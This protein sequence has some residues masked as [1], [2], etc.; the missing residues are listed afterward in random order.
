MH[1]RQISHWSLWCF[2]VI[3]VNYRTYEWRLNNHSQKIKL[4]LVYKFLF[5]KSRP[6][7]P[8]WGGMQPVFYERGRGHCTW[9]HFTANVL[10]LYSVCWRRGLWRVFVAWP[11]P[12][13]PVRGSKGVE[14]RS[15]K[16]SGLQVHYRPRSPNGRWFWQRW[17]D[18]PPKWIFWEKFNSLA[19]TTLCL[20]QKMFTA[21]AAPGP[22]TIKMRD[23]KGDLTI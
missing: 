10:T 12:E 9:P 21:E 2:R 1:G 4:S 8:G 14:K 18:S 5:T 16:N 6:H 15:L 19:F 11:G 23:V 22:T 3:G 13:E 7:L 20:R 17:P